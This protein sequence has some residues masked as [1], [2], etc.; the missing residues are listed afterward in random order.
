MTTTMTTTERWDIFEA[1]FRSAAAADAANPFRDIAFSAVFTLGNRTVPVTGFHDGGDV[2]R[3]RFM[4]DAEG[5]WTL[6]TRSNDPALDGQQAAF[7]CIAPAKGNHG[8]VRVRDRFHFEYADGTPYFPFGT[9][10]YAWTQQPLAMQEQT[11]ATLAG[12]PFNKIRMGFF[13]KD[14]NFSTN[15]PLMDCYQ[16]RADGTLDF[17]RP[18]PAAFAHFDAQIERLRDMGI[19]ADVILFHPYDRWG[20]ADMTEDQD[21]AY[22]R[23]MAARLSGYRNVWWSLANEYDFLLNTKPMLFW[24]RVFQLLEETDPARHLASIHNGD[25]DAAYDHRKPWVSHVCLQHWDVKRTAEWRHVW[26]KPLVNDE[27]QY[28]GNIWCAWGSITPQEL[29]HRYWLTL[30]RGGYAGHGETYEDP[31]DLL[32]WAKGGVLHGDAPARIGFLRGLVEAHAPAGL[33][34]FGPEWPWSRVSGAASGDTT[35]IY[36]GEHQPALWSTGLPVDTTDCRVTV[37]DTWAMTEEPAQIVPAFVPHRSRHGG[38]VRGGTPD[39]A[40]AVRLPGR[41]WLALRVT[42]S[43]Q[44][45]VS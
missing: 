24:D 26:G 29:V 23:Y 12:A 36:F 28:E 10:C 25:P 33:T 18:N 40:F 30:V 1:E 17:D 31:D 6:R 7:T 14:Y 8:P 11:L 3:L 45:R 41:P 44:G 19:E 15:E 16:R 39:A 38:V 2:W 27:P 32:W 4:P 37:I 20:Y 34:P 43:P 42:R 21:F 13:P 35:F 22:V 5:E 9:T